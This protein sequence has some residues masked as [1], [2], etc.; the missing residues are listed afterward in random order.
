VTVAV[1]SGV[2]VGA[3]ED[4]GTG[5]R[6]R[7]RGVMKAGQ[8]QRVRGQ[9]LSVGPKAA[10]ALGIGGQAEAVVAPRRQGGGWPGCSSQARA[11]HR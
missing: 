7:G 4:Q 11:H 3:G 8:H 9:A 2:L 1:G 5:T 6:D 10:V